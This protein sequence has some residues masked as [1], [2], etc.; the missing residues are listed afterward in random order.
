[1][2]D[3]TILSRLVRAATDERIW[4]DAIQALAAIVERHLE[5]EAP[6]SGCDIA[7]RLCLPPERIYFALQHLI[8]LEIVQITHGYVGEPGAQFFTIAADWTEDAP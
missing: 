4:P 5:G 8:K 3:A 1:M 6:L 7:A 2:S